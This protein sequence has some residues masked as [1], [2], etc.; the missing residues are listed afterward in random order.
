MLF[1]APKCI[2]STQ[3]PH[4]HWGGGTPPP[5]TLLPLSAQVRP[6]HLWRLYPTPS[7]YSEILH[8]P[9]VRH[10]LFILCSWILQVYSEKVQRIP[11]WHPTIISAECCFLSEAFVFVIQSAGFMCKL[12]TCSVF[13][14][15]NLLLVA[16]A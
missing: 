1:S 9:L 6:Q 7:P 11:S 15:V 5:H 13:A 14:R 12:L 8:Q 4:P 2:I 10:L 3:R 16:E